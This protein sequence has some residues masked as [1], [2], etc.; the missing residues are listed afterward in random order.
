MNI[1]YITPY[2]PSLIRVRPYNLVKYLSRQGH[3]VTVLSLKASPQE[4]AD[5]EELRKHCAHV[6]TVE[7]SRRESLS[8]CIKALP[9]FTPLQAAFCHSPAMTHLIKR[10]LSEEKYDLIHVEH[11]RGAHFGFVAKHLPKVYDSVDCISLLFER[12][13]RQAPGLLR[14]FVARLDLRRTKRYEGWLLEQY[15]KV[16]VTS[17]SDKMALESLNLTKWDI[18]NFFSKN[19]YTMDTASSIAQRIGRSPNIVQPELDDLVMLGLLEQTSLN[20][21]RVYQLTTREELQE[22]VFGFVEGFNDHPGRLEELLSNLTNG[23]DGLGKIS[24]LPNGVDLDYFAAANGP[25]EPDTLIFSGKMSYHAN[26]AAALNLVQKIMPLIWAER[27]NVKVRI[28][29][30]DP[31]PEVKALARD[32]R[33][34]VEGYVPDLRPYLAGAT[35]SVSP[36]RYGVGIQN[37]VLEAMAVGTPVVTT[38]VACSALE[39]KDNEHLL[40]ADDPPTFARKVLRLLDDAF[41]WQKISKSGRRYVEEKH[42]WKLIAGRLEEIYQEVIAKWQKHPSVNMQELVPLGNKPGPQ[43][44]TS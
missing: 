17:W 39:A 36:M 3:Q 22:I 23:E 2:V 19:P 7:L 29:G 26:M 8:N 41:L 27:P 15:D 31:P 21:E 1:L 28:V 5:A 40:V 10:L 34:S 30:K 25:R 33:V 44:G 12:A 24:V 11:L 13:A 38:S 42:D 9:G 4:E 6:E 35:V 18:L 16:L 20:G 32:K 37:K 14:R 43:Y